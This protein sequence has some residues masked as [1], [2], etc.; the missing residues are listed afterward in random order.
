MFAVLLV[1]LSYRCVYAVIVSMMQSS[2][3]AMLS[4]GLPVR[5]ARLMCRC[6]SCE[7]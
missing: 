7:L 3:R 4:R 6:R 5:F 1:V 2:G